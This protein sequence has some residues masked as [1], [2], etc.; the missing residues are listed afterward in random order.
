MA[1]GAHVQLQQQ[2]RL[3]QQA[4]SN[5]QESGNVEFGGV[6]MQQAA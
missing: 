4:A 3:R 1:V 6:D 5:L 2:Q